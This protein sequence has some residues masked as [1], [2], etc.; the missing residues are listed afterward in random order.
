M[1]KII[2]I[3]ALLALGACTVLNTNNKVILDDGTKVTVG[4]SV[5]E[6]TGSAVITN[7]EF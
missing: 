7:G 2:A 6:T 3:G 1:K 4:I 5:E